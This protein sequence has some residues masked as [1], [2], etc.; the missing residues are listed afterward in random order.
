MSPAPRRNPLPAAA[1]WA[2]IAVLVAIVCN[3]APALPSRAAT[4]QEVDAA[5]QKGK[6]FLRSQQRP[7]GSWE[8]TSPPAPRDD[9]QGGNTAMATYALLAAGDSPQ[10]EHVKKAVSWL[11]NAKITGIYALGLRC[12]VWP[13][14]KRSDAVRGAVIRDADALLKSCD[15]SARWGYTVKGGNEHNSPTQ[16]GVL[17]LWACDRAGFEVPTLFWK[18]SE[19]S[20]FDCQGS[21]GAWGYRSVRPSMPKN[22]PTTSM[23]LAGLASLFIAQDYVHAND[24]VRCTGNVTNPHIELGLKWLSDNYDPNWSDG[25]V[26]YGVERT[27]VASGYKYF[28]SHDWYALGAETLVRT[29]REDGSWP[30]SFISKSDMPVPGTS[31][32]LFFLTR[33]RAPIAVNKLQ[34]GFGP[35]P[36]GEAAKGEARPPAAAT[37]KG[38]DSA[39][40]WNQRPRDV[41]NVV[42][43]MGTALERDLNWQIVNLSANAADLL[44]APLLYMAGDQ[45]L[46]LNE[47]DKQKLRSYV[48]Q[49]GI[50]LGQ[51]DCAKAEFARSFKALGGELFP[52]YEFRTLPS[53]HFVFT[54]QY[55]ASKW[56][57][58][59][60]VE[61]L[62]NG[63]REL[64]LLVPREDVG[65]TWQLQLTGPKE[66]HFQLLSNLF[67]YAVDRADMRY[68]G[69]TYVI[70]PDAAITPKRTI[71]LARV[72]YAGNW[73]PEPGGWRRMA[74]YLL[75]NFELG[76]DV[77]V[78]KVGG[79][80]VNPAHVAGSLKGYDVAH[81]T[82]TDALKLSE[83]ARQELRRFVQTG[84]TL[85][86]D[87]AG[88][89]TPFADAAEQVLADVFKPLAPDAAEQLSRPAKPD[90]AV[91][92]LPA[93][94]LAEV[95]YRTFARTQLGNTR[96]P[97]L[98]IITVKNRP[99]VFF[100]K[101]DLSTGLVGQSVDGIYGY[102]PRTATQLAANVI[103]LATGEGNSPPATKPATT[104]SSTK[105]ADR[106]PR[107]EP[108][109]AGRPPG[110]RPPG[111]GPPG[112][113]RRPPPTR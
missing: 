10:E 74:A 39:A 109:G 107:D 26:L 95:G 91:Y 88:G 48:E 99:A 30:Y 24:G 47:A 1:R 75:N 55:P 78:E 42:R 70:T 106:P 65:K 85:L 72:R 76:L 29:Q 9:Q 37:A 36:N 54:E 15:K 18:R 101:E 79:A 77:K 45:E 8:P 108:P 16:Y 7:D 13:Y 83:E 33:G 82:G 19:K 66:H 113:P 53:N 71:K 73:D 62:S 14:L 105:P 93:S 49:G 43:W 58:K 28:G 46:R 68:K 40:N 111:G 51:A 86:V 11:M 41:A 112:G 20:W 63:S 103:L 102:D 61:G 50:I 32:A 60:E 67:L 69:D 57:G 34:Y 44:D 27:G 80:G 17:G 97:R 5:I 81:L 2:T 23:T 104:R 56:K 52:A 31:F 100:S 92:T 98:R 84:G 4:P 6:K 59:I 90:S 87:A 94:K 110:P 38:K 22:A 35:A 64:M 96:A 89:N 25:Y 12:Q 21:D 3:L